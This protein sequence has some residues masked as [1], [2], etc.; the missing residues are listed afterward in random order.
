MQE[1]ALSL[2]VRI[3]LRQTA[4]HW[5]EAELLEQRTELFRRALHGVVA[6]I[7][8][9]VVAEARCPTCGGRICR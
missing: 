4:V 3:T 8:A 2:T 5:L 1:I 6:Q 7:E 9:A